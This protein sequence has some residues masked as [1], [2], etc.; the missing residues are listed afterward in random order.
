MKSSYRLLVACLFAAAPVVWSAPVSSGSVV[1]VLK[2]RDGWEL[3]V[4]GKPFFVKG[5]GCNDAV[6]EK[7]E[8]YLRMAHEM[9][10]NAVRIWGG[11]TREYLD[12]AHA[13]GLMVNLGFWLNP[14]RD[15][16]VE[17]YRDG[18]HLAG[19]KHLILSHVDEMKDH[20]A[21]LSWTIGNEVFYWTE[22]EEEKAEFGRFLEEII[23]EIHRQDPNHP[24]VY[25]ASPPEILY[26]KKY[27]PS[28]DIVG[29]NVYGDFSGMVSS[30]K[31]VGYEKPVM[32]TEFG[33][34]GSWEMR[35]DRNQLPYDAFDHFKA[36]NYEKIW[37]Q[38][39]AVRPRSLGG[40]AFVLGNQRNQDSLTWYN[41]NFGE[42]R[43]AGY[44]TLYSLYT[45]QKPPRSVPKIVQMTLKAP[46]PLQPKGEFTIGFSV[47]SSSG[48][49][50]RYQ[51]MIT[52]IFSDAIALQA[53]RFFPAEPV[54]EA[55][56]Q[57]RL[58]A[59][60]DPGFYRV[61]VMVSDNHQNIAIADRT[62]HVVP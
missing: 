30:L 4:N 48:D 28:L 61:Y 47:S 51:Y 58:R 55:P 42:R 34:S 20:P 5:V 1:K 25:A 6:G 21:L 3:S 49:P 45:G 36:Q 35:K 14:I 41:V 10:A 17:S 11:A 60:A 44:W 27:L 15:K 43:R 38:I 12:Q 39:E 33:P 37:Y 56:G 57:A 50:L 8:D 59:P 19:L 29:A 16:T 52:D 22:N 32:A 62:I 7:G 2:I 18:G 24:V 13:N 53:P 46:T 26:L 9:G 40:F 31:S 23:R 54:E